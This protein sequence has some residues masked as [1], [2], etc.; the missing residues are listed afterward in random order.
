MIA[1]AGVLTL[2]E[3]I[4]LEAL[5]CGEDNACCTNDCGC[6]E[7]VDPP[8]FNDDPEDDGE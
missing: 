7:P 1:A 6:E 8:I 4:Q 3:A 5:C 2:T